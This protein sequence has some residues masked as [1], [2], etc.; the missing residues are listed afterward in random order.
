MTRIVTLSSRLKKATDVLLL[1]LL[2]LAV[3]FAASVAPA[4][5]YSTT[6]PLTENPIS[7]GVNWINGGTVGLD[8][9]NV[10]TT[11][12]LAFGTQPSGGFGYDDSTALLTGTWGPTQT[13]S[14]VVHIV[15]ADNGQFEE[16][17]LRLRS[18]ISA[19]S[20]TGYEFNFGVKSGDPYAQI[21]RWNGALGNWTGL[22]G[23][24]VAP[25]TNGTVV[26]A[27]AVNN[28]LTTYING[29]AIFSVTDSTFPTGNPGIG[30]YLA[31]DGFGSNYGFSSFNATDDIQPIAP[32]LSP[33]V[34]NGQ[35]VFSFQTVAAQ[36]YAVQQNTDLGTA[37]WSTVTNIQGTGLACEFTAPLTDAQPAVFF[38]V[39]A[40]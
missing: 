27:T 39:Q 31:G 16:V 34:T 5:S 19:H 23:R 24:T 3:D 13:V 21:V 26:K 38:R 20:C 33:A 36:T 2:A 1:V 35:F 25:I 7:E 11:P 6:F 12:G 30:F 40:L 14:A 9:Y 18:S 10:A 29:V 15:N 28:T 32:I 37:N 8:W 17:E 4:E 22:D